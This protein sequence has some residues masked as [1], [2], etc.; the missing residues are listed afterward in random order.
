MDALNPIPDALSFRQ[1]SELLDQA[2]PESRG[3]AGA[4]AD[5][6]PQADALAD[7]QQRLVSYA[8]LSRRLLAELE[9]C[10]PAM[11]GRLSGRQLMALGSFRTHLLMGLRAL[12][13][14]QP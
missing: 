13:A 12:S 6:D 11:E 5:A 10:T 14:G 8:D 7:L 2:P 3:G 4:P 9:R 1:L